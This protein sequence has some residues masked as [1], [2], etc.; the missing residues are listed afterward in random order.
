MTDLVPR[1][2]PGP[3]AA[4]REECVQQL[5]RLRYMR[6]VTYS[7]A[8]SFFGWRVVLFDGM[9][10][11][12]W[13]VIAVIAVALVLLVEVSARTARKHGWR[14]PSGYKYLHDRAVDAYRDAPPEL[15]PVF[16]DN[17]R[18]IEALCDAGATDRAWEHVNAMGD[19]LTTWRHVRQRELEEGVDGSALLALKQTQESLT[20]VARMIDR[21]GQS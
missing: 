8:V 9:P 6:I 5:P 18:A 4:W 3:R 7:F 1:Y 17:L 14:R 20:E 10:T 13:F 16:A 12:S 11:P 2:A 19:T 21:E 15:Q